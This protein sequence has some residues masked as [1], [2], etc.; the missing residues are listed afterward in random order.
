[1]VVAA[2]LQREVCPAPRIA[3]GAGWMSPR[4]TGEDT[5]VNVQTVHLR[6]PGDVVFV[7]HA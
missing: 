7:T 1:M 6:C 3:V 4:V 2:F 5:Q